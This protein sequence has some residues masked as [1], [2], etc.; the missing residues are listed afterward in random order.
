MSQKEPRKDLR[1]KVVVVTGASS[2]FGKGAARAYAAAGASVVVAARREHLIQ[3]LA[4]EIGGAGG[5]ALAVTTDVSRREDV[6]RLGR[7]AVDHFGRIDVWINDAGVGAIGR[8][9]EVPVSDHVQVIETDLLGTLYGSYVAMQQFRRQKAGTLINISSVVGKVPS[10]Y[11]ASYSAAKCGIVGLSAA[12]RQELRLNKVRDIHVCTVLPTTFDTPFFDHVS[13]YTGHE[14][15][16][17][18]PV[19]EPERVIEVLVRLATEPEDEV[20]VGAA[21]KVTGVAH[22]LAP[23]AT[24]RLWA[25]QVHRLQM[26]QA[27]PADASKGAVHE[28]V[29]AGTEVT[30]GRVF[31]N[32]RAAA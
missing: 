7:Q 26:E 9:E 1:G 11:Y 20:M 18:P 15:K 31:K 13:N 19:Y 14:V 5:R 27:A 12:L 30:A 32:K 17:I 28:P 16:L 24:E 2:G 8:F 25:T 6:E 22:H 4:R 21:A 3:E 23:D 10:P 29:P